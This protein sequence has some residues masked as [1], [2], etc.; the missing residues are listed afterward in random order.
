[1]KRNI[2][3]LV[4]LLGTIHLSLRAQESAVSKPL[5]FR[6]PYEDYLRN[7]IEPR[8]AAW[9]A[10]DRYVESPKQYEERVSEE[11]TKKKYAEWK[12]EADSIYQ[13]KFAETV[14]WKQFRLV[15]NYDPENETVMVGSEQFGPFAVHVPKGDAARQFVAQFDSLQVVGFDFIFTGGDAVA[16][17]RLTFALPSLGQQFAYDSHTPLQHKE[18]GDMAIVH[19]VEIPIDQPV[20]AT[21][22]RTSAFLDDGL[23][24]DSVI[25]RTD[26]VNEDVYGVIIGNE[27]Y[28]YES[29]TR[30]SANDA[31][32][33]Y[34]YCTRTLGIPA[35]NLSLK[36][37]ATYGDML[38]AIQF[39]KNAATAKNGNI[40]LLFYFSGHGMS[41]L[42]ENNMYLLPVDC[43][44][45]TLQAALKA[46][47]LYKE[48]SD[49]KTL[50]ATVFLDACFS[51]KSSEGA[52]TALMDGAGIEITPREAS[53]YGNLVVFSATTD[54]EIAYPYEAR[55]HRM[56]TYFLLKKLQAEK[57]DVT[58]FDLAG[59]VTNQVK[60]H[61]F[62]INKKMQTPKV[63]GS[64]DITGVWGNWKLIK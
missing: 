6:I 46:E 49:M 4:F 38:N 55:Q 25:P 36:K 17:N 2:C 57:G 42:K 35:G 10:W 23:N 37:D 54:A 62:D 21:R 52:L 51:G 5:R 53:L 14:R 16:L 61:A 12:T 59:Y 39:L 7:Y 18:V 44:S 9:T 24:V 1:M 32:V 45:N 20:P 29:V 27:N 30:F 50:S 13:K 11:N 33:F 56:F 60:S 19:R 26:R 22:E 48:L 58:Y 63:Q 8:V 3:I 15:G 34:E 40:R 28:F 47:T 41:D 43:S 64:H 31:T